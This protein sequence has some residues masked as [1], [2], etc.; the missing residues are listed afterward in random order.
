MVLEV[1][2]GLNCEGDRGKHL[3]L[4]TDV[5]FGVG[6]AALA[7]SVYLLLDTA[8]SPQRVSSASWRPLGGVDARGGWLGVGHSF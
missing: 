4:V 7:A 5:G 1:C 8:P 6:L 2:P 3:A